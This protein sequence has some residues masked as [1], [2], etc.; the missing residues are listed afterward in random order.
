MMQIFAFG[1]GCNWNLIYVEVFSDVNES[2][3]ELPLDDRSSILGV[4]REL[5]CSYHFWALVT[6]PTFCPVGTRNDFPWS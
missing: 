2:C 6:T 3:T 5:A 1:Q 4:A